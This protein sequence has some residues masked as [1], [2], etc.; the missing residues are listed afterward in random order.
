MR[1]NKKNVW[2]KIYIFKFQIQ[3]EVLE[4]YIQYLLYPQ[5]HITKKQKVKRNLH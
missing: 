2:I 1:I 5:T 3:T 4:F